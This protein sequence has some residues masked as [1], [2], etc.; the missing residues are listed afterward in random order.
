MG[1]RTSASVTVG[2]GEALHPGLMA[3]TEMIKLCSFTGHHFRWHDA[4]LG[5]DG[6]HV[7]SIG[8]T[9]WGIF[10]SVRLTPNS[11]S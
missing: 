11:R 10:V 9:I 6:I 8:E 5:K 2:A 7:G 3:A 4:E 1:K